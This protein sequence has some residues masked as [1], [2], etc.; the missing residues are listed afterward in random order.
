MLQGVRAHCESL[1]TYFGE[2]PIVS[3]AAVVGGDSI[4]VMPAP[5]LVTTSRDLNSWE[6]RESQGIDRY[7]TFK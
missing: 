4:D 2:V 7:E 5:A 3:T 6:N 1:L